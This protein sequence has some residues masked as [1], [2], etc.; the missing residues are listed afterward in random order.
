MNQTPVIVCSFSGGETSAYMAFYLQSKFKNH[1]IINVFAN[2]GDEWE[3]TL[4]FADKC[5]K[6]FG[7]NLVWVESV[8][9]PEY[10]KGI[11]AK[12]VDFAN[13]SRNAEPFRA[14]VAKH[15]IP[16]I[17]SKHCSRELKRYAITAY[18]RS[19]G[20][21]KSDYKIAIGIRADE[22]DRVSESATKDNIFYPLLESNHPRIDK[23][24]INRFW[25][26]QPFRLNLK[27]YEGNCKV[28][29][30]KTLRKLLTIAKEKP[31]AF[32]QFAEMEK[33]FEKYTPKSKQ[34]NP[35]IKPPHRFF[36]NN[37]SVKDIL[38]MSEQPFEPAKDG[39]TI[40]HSYTQNALFGIEL[41]KS[42]G[43]VE[44]CEVF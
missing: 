40:Y 17:A 35:L 2:T 19:V 14:M 20:L 16:N 34:H 12:V 21:K 32:N 38:K 28:C 3:E 4:V 13:A 30:K 37:L 7:L 23:P 18:L 27:S 9:N 39:S 8:T 31:E 42:L 26:E 44:S 5:D 22:I 1:N 15:G 10:R 29:W 11:T 25:R 6:Y 36:T 24:F 43:C 41:D 33:D